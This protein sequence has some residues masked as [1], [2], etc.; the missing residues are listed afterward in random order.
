MIIVLI[1]YMAS[2]KSVIGKKLAEKLN[3]KFIDLDHY[4][5]LKE[6][7][8]ITN[9]FTTKS[10]LFFRILENKYL[11]QIIDN[12]TNLVLALGGGTPCYS[13]NMKLLTAAENCTTIYLSASAS[14][15]VSRLKDEKGKR[16]LVAHISS[17]AE[18]SEFIR[19]HLFERM[20]Y[21]NQADVTISIDD[22]SS[23]HIIE[24]IILQLF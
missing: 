11:A 8:T 7:S 19:K 14:L 5:E 21:Y 13:N 24:S 2:G 23:V 16:P 17:E 12:Q 6:E 20:V 15:L 18:L 22:K 4:I 9:I 3:Y 10:E 1:G